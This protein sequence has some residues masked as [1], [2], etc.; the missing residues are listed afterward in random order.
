MVYCD[1]HIFIYFI[2]LCLGSV[3]YYLVFFDLVLIW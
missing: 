1:N 3:G 2:F